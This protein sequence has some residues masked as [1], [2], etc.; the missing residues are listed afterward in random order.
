MKFVLQTIFLALSGLFS[1]GEGVWAQGSVLSMEAR[2]QVDHLE[3][4]ERVEESRS[5]RIHLLNQT[6]IEKLEKLQ[7]RLV[8]LNDEAGARAV[9]AEIVQLGKKTPD[10]SVKADDPQILNQFREVYLRERQAI[11][12][13]IAMQ[14]DAL[15][16]EYTIAKAKLASQQANESGVDAEPLANRVAPVA[17]PIGNPRSAEERNSALATTTKQRRKVIRPTIYGER[18]NREYVLP[19]DDFIKIV[20][21]EPNARVKL[22]Q[23]VAVT[24][25]YNKKFSGR[26][27]LML[28]PFVEDGANRCV[29]RSRNLYTRGDGEAVLYLKADGETRVDGIRVEMVEAISGKHITRDTEDI[30]VA[31]LRVAQ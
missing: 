8:E 27:R 26:A 14:R 21:V 31:W 29:S 20:S 13:D 28:Y 23:R 4:L 9:A 1:L 3:S 12:T 25:A 7:A 24:V 2:L 5:D 16:A 18:D 17:S 30:K 19:D 10:I 22:G 11:I 6:C 15:V